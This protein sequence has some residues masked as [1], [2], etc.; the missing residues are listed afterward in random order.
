[1]KTSLLFLMVTAEKALLDILLTHINTVFRALFFLSSI[2]N[3]R[4]GD[5][6][7]REH[8]LSRSKLQNSDCGK[9]VMRL[10]NSAISTTDNPRHYPRQKDK[11]FMGSPDQLP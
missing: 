11:K 10:M 6:E 1:M 4:R 2:V 8:S 3:R 9:N 7:I 5:G